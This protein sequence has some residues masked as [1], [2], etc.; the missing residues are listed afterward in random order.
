MVINT[1]D[2]VH[3]SVHTGAQWSILVLGLPSTAKLF[4]KGPMKYK[5]VTL[6]KTENV[7][8]KEHSKWLGVQ[9]CCCFDR[10]HHRNSITRYSIPELANI[11][12][13]PMS[14]PVGLNT[15]AMLTLLYLLHSQPP[16]SVYRRSPPPTWAFSVYVTP[17]G[18]F[19]FCFFFS[20]CGG[21]VHNFIWKRKGG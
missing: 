8:L 10:L 4:P 16:A 18:Q 14:W 20:C 6:L 7:H 9:N 19:C 1:F 17:G 2:S 3:Q 11:G 13:N 15:Q 21:G 5:S 12:N